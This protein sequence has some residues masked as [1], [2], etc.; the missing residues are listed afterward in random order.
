[1]KKYAAIFI[2]M[3]LVISITVPA[4][5]ENITYDTPVQGSI[6]ILDGTFA[7]MNPNNGEAT[8]SGLVVQMSDDLK[9]TMQFILHAG[10]NNYPIEAAGVLEEYI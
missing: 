3:L 8:Y 4:F 2:A 9:C 7:Q 10:S 5:A 6:A 1:M